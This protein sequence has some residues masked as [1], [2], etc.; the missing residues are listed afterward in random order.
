MVAIC[1]LAIVTI[2]FVLNY[3]SC[4]FFCLDLVLDTKKCDN[5]IGF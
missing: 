4:F 2:F 5:Y 3:L 1:Y